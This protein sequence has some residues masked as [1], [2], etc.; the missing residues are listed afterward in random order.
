MD[1]HTGEKIKDSL[2]H[3]HTLLR[4]EQGLF[5]CESARKRVVSMDEPDILDIEKGYVRGLL[6]TRDEI[7]VGV[8]HARKR[9]KS[10]GKLNKMDDELMR[11]FRSGCG[12]KIYK[13]YGKKL[14][15]SEFLKFI[16]LYPFSNEIYDLILI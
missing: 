13:R 8:S 4:T 7:A 5:F 1:I 2:F 16:D 3:P 9:S 14:K 10:T 6:I 12:V 15:E 11:S